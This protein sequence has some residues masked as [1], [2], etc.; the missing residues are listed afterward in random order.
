MAPTLPGQARLIIALAAALA[1][2]C[3]AAQD[4]WLSM[5]DGSSLRGWQETA[6]SGRG[7]VTVADGA[8][9]LGAGSLTGVS[10]TRAFPST[11]FEL[12]LEAM[13]A[14][15]DDF[16]AGITFP[17]RGSFCSWIVGGWG[18]TVVGLSSLDGMDASEND[19]STR[20]EFE[21]GRWY[22]L[23]LVVTDERI[24]AWIDAEKVIDAVLA[25][26]TIGLRPGEIERSKPLGVAS[27]WTTARLRKIEYRLLTPGNR[28]AGK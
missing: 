21:T 4:G 7:K 25:N 2:P 9:V 26:R 6:F 8:I 12:R 22:A 27:Y 23:R 16:F 11:N 10:W 20:R 24:S 19:T 1:P 13:R 3:G 14:G 28:A 5:F 17:V 18:G 15:G